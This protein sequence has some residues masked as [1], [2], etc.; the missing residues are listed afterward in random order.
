MSEYSR[1]LAAFESNDHVMIQNQSG[2]FPKK[3]DKCGIVVGTKGNDQYVV[4]T[5][6]SEGLMLKKPFVPVEI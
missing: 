3:W 5:L 4:K 2:M 1:L 6:S